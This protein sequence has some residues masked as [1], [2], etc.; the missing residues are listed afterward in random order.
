[1]YTDYEIKT[2]DIGVYNLNGVVIEQGDISP[3]T[4]EDTNSSTRIRT[5]GYILVEPDTEYTFNSN[6]GKICIFA[7][8]SNNISNYLGASSWQTIP[9][10]YTTPS[11]CR[12]IRAVFELGDD[13]EVTPESITRLRISKNKITYV[14]GVKI[15]DGRAYVQD[16][17]FLHEIP[18]EIWDHIYNT[19]IHVT[20]EDKAFW[21]DK[22]NIIDTHDEDSEDSEVIDET[23]EFSREFFNGSV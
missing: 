12:Y 3:S 1:M 8:P 21:G 4:G 7:Y 22:I 14:P 23:I 11:N 15:G 10:T 2:K 16:L 13:V 6:M 5:K 19:D 20:P 17:P 9:C 18:Q